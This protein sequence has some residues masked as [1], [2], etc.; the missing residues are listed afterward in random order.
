MRCARRH[1][2]TLATAAVS[3]H[4]CTMAIRWLGWVVRSGGS[5]PG[6]VCLVAGCG[7]GRALVGRHLDG[8]GVVHA[9]GKFVCKQ[10]VSA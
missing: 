3:I 4:K 8:G 2:T 5:K 10:D 9:R 7:D 6:R 1:G